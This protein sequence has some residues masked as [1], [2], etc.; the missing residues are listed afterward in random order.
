[1]TNQTSDS[2]QWWLDGAPI[3]GENDSI[4]DLTSWLGAGWFEVEN[5]DLNG[6]SVFSDSLLYSTTG[7]EEN[8]EEISIYPNP[9]YDVLNFTGTVII[10]EIMI[11]DISGK[12]L[13]SVQVK[14]NSGSIDVRD[15]AS[16]M[17]ILRF[18]TGKES[19]ISKIPIAR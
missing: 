16:G 19:H 12:L 6:C 17:Y 13:Q 2:I 11:L 18:Y 5:I 3:V 15:L 1:M 9:A 4:L 14:S 8:G 10:D 7:I